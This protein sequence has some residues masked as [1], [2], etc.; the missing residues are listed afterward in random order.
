MV[1]RTFL[2]GSAVALSAICAPLSVFGAEDK[3]DVRMIGMVSE[4]AGMTGYTDILSSKLDEM[5]VLG[6]DRLKNM[7]TLLLAIF[8]GL[9][10][11]SDYAILSHVASISRARVVSEVVHMPSN[12][13]INHTEN[14]FANVSVKKAFDSFA[15]L[16]ACQYGV[17]LSSY[18]T[19]GL[20]NTHRVSKQIDFVS[21]HTTKNAFV[22][23]I[24]KA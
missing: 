9:M 17:A 20:L 24:I 23:F 22:S 7:N 4:S 8:C 10:E 11:H 3:S 1:R 16:D 18:H 12:G 13:V 6:T 2:K 14:S 5:I 21:K 19:T 15:S